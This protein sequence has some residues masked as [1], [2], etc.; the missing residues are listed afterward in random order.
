MKL[1]N[2]QKMICLFIAFVIIIQPLV[3]S[4]TVTAEEA[5]PT[6]ES[7]AQGQLEV[8]NEYGEIETI[9]IEKLTDA[10][11][12]DAEG[13]GDDGIRENPEPIDYTSSEMLLE[14]KV[15]FASSD[16]LLVSKLLT[17]SSLTPNFI[18]DPVALSL[19]SGT[20]E[21][22]LEEMRWSDFENYQ[23]L[24]TK[25]Q[26]EIGK[27]YLKGKVLADPG[28]IQKLL[29]LGSE[30]AA[31]QELANNRKNVEEEID[32][33]LEY[34]IDKKIVDML[35]YL[36]RPKD[37]PRGGAGHWKIKV[38]RLF[39]NYSS[40]DRQFSKES[41][42]VA[43]SNEESRSTSAEGPESPTLESVK[44]N[45]NISE[46]EKTAEEIGLN[47]SESLVAGEIIDKDGNT[48]SDF[49]INA[50]EAPS[51]ISS[52]YKG[53]AVD[54]SALDDIRCTKIEKKR[55]GSDKKTVQA[56]Q[57]IKFLWQTTEGY[58]KDRKSID[59]SYDK[60]MWNMGQDALLTMLSGL[61]LDMDNIETLDVRN[62]SDLASVIGQAFF[63]NALNSSG[64]DI[65]K[66][67]L[68]STLEK[69]GGIIIADALK[70]DRR[71]FLDDSLLSVDSISE[72]IGRAG[73][74]KRLG[75][76]Y[77]AL[78]GS[79]RQEM[80]I[81]VG[82]ARLLHE[83]SLPSDTLE[84]IATN[85]QEELLFRIG[86]R[87]FEDDLGLNKDS[88]YK[89][90][91]FTQ[92]SE[93]NGKYR[94][95]AMFSIH[96]SIDNL[97]GIAD[98]SS[99]RFKAGGLTAREYGK[100][101]ALTHLMNT[102]YKYANYGQGSDP[103][104]TPTAYTSNNLKLINWRD[105]MF[106][107]PKGTIDFFLGAELEE[108]DYGEIG[109]FSLSRIFENSDIGRSNFSAWLRNPSQNFIVAGQTKTVK[110]QTSNTPIETNGATNLSES[111][112]T[113]VSA[114]VT[115]PR[116]S[117]ASIMGI[118]NEEVYSVLGSNQPAQTS[119]VFKR[120]G[121]RIFV[122]ALKNSSAVKEQTNEFLRDHPDLQEN[123]NTYEFYNSRYKKIKDRLPKL[124]EKSQALKES[125]E[126]LDASF[127]GDEDKAFVLQN[128]QS[129]ES[130]IEGSKEKDDADY[131]LEL[132]RR[133]VESGNS[134]NRS[135]TVLSDAVQRNIK[136]DISNFRS[137][138]NAY[139]YEV[140]FISKNAYEILTG[141][142]Q[143][144][145]RLED[146]EIKNLESRNISLGGVSISGMELAMFLTG[147]VK[148]KELMMSI[149]SAKLADS[150][151][152]PPRALKYA[153]KL[154]RK[155]MEKKSDPKNAF[156]RAIGLSALELKLN[157]NN[158]NWGN[159]VDVEDLADTSDIRGFRDKLAVRLD[160]NKTR[161]N[162]VIAESLG[163]KGYNLEYLMRG[164][165]GAWA[166]ARA[167]AEANDKELGIPIGTTEN[168]VKGAPL[169][170]AANIAVTDD[171]YRQ[172]ATKLDISEASLRLFVSLANGQEN[173][174]INEIYFVDR[175]RYRTTSD[176]PDVCSGKTVPD[177]V[178]MYYD[179]DG[180]HYF[181]S[182]PEAN[183]FVK[184]HEHRKINYLDDIIK[185]LAGIALQEPAP[186]TI[187]DEQ[188][189]RIKTSLEEYVGGTSNF[190]LAK[191]GVD[192]EQYFGISMLGLNVKGDI[193]TDLFEKF[194]SHGKGP[195]A[196]ENMSIDLLKTTGIALLKN[197]GAS[198]LGQSL[199]MNLGST[200]LTT[201]DIY[202]ALNGNS[203]EVF[204]RIGG[205]MLDQE[206]GLERGT[207]ENILAGNSSSSRKC[208]IERAATQILGDALGIEGLE[209]SG[210]LF[211]NIGGSKIERL[212]G[213][214]EGSF[215]GKNIA[216]LLDPNRRNHVPY[217]DF[218]KGFSLPVNP[219][220]N[221]LVDDALAVMGKEYYERFKNESFY[222]KA[223]A[224]NN[225]IE[226]VGVEYFKGKDMPTWFDSSV[227]NLLFSKEI[228]YFLT[229]LNEKK[230]NTIAMGL[231]LMEYPGYADL[232][233]EDIVESLKGF[234]KR[235][236]SIDSALNIDKGYTLNL[237]LDKISPDDYRKKVSNTALGDIGFEALKQAFGIESDITLG[238]LNRFKSAVTGQLT[239]TYGNGVTGPAS[240]NLHL[241]EIYK[242]L[243][244]A[245]SLKLDEQAGFESGTIASFIQDPSKATGILA[246][247]SAKRLD[248][249]LGIDDKGIN[250]SSYVQIFVDNDPEK[251]KQTCLQT[252]DFDRC[253]N[254]ERVR[255]K[256]DS[257]IM[258]EDI[259]AGHIGNFLSDVSG[260]EVE[261]EQTSP[262]GQKVTSYQKRHGITLSKDH[263]KDVF[264]GD[265]R[266]FGV[267]AAIRG[268][269]AVLGDENGR[270]ALGQDSDGFLFNPQDIVWAFYG[271]P[272]TEEYAAQ[273]AREQ[274]YAEHN[275]SPETIDAAI[276]IVS[277]RE[278]TGANI[279]LSAAATF[280][281]NP[282]A[283]TSDSRQ[284]TIE[285]ANLTY[286][287]PETTESSPPVDPSI[288]DFT[289]PAGNVDYEGYDAA[290]NRNSI[291]RLDADN[292]A[293]RAVAEDRKL[294]RELFEYRV[295]DCM[296]RKIDKR[297]PAGFS[298]SMLKGNSFVRSV[299]L[300]NYIE[301]WLRQDSDGEWKKYLPKG[302]LSFI[303][304]YFKGPHRG[305]M[306]RLIN[307]TTGNILQMVDDYLM[308]HSPKVFGLT[309][310]PG[311]AQGL[312]AFIKTGNI[313]DAVMIGGK[314]FSLTGVY[315]NYTS[316]TIGEHIGGW[317]DDK[318]GLPPGTSYQIYSNLK[319]L[320]ATKI[321]SRGIKEGL[322]ITKTTAEISGLPV[323]TKLGANEVIGTNA[324]TGE[325]LKGD[326]LKSAKS[327]ANQKMT[328]IKASLVTI[329][330]TALF[331]KQIAAM[332]ESLGLVPGS[333]GLL[334]G[335][336][337]GWLMGAS[338]NPIGAA[339]FV[340]M[341]L[342]GVYKVEVICTADGYYPAVQPKTDST[343]WD[344]PN[345]GT[346]NAL[347][348]K[349][350]EKRYIEASQYKTNRLAI[351]LFEM[352]VR[353]GDKDLV[354]LQVMTGREESALLAKPLVLENLCK[355]KFDISEFMMGNNDLETAV[356]AGTKVGIWKN[357]QN[358]DNTHIGF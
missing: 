310:A 10:E 264:R 78:K 111:N 240:I 219:Q 139:N 283:T 56:P 266:I 345:L 109:I 115:L 161:A 351:D 317:V 249:S 182:Y 97:F 204:A 104:Q 322:V 354:P 92:M 292:A 258:V 229:L 215:R 17:V 96:S 61:N 50:E 114:D 185:G 103:T 113:T 93:A 327:N 77:G 272:L 281:E 257:R 126:R 293:A 175:N 260:V 81:N 68:G 305:D 91:S 156:Y 136:G 55:I 331:S 69:I 74:E 284:A 155:S 304:E 160:N 84:G 22:E 298:W 334:V 238:D 60:M 234:E 86:A 179:Q 206:I 120:L 255:E 119:G 252:P 108:D 112:T 262:Y 194:F 320:H 57:D 144:D 343:K 202:E 269:G 306:D 347:N 123:I 116:D 302:S 26:S 315:K 248:A 49:L 263:I 200:R 342:F 186:Y 31:I 150:L 35:A 148:A 289:D 130:T 254:K 356:C 141:Q 23:Q 222:E 1:I 159:Q 350:R 8:V 311:T 309:L 210:S 358:N 163:L 224:A 290:L 42:A 335:M 43:R 243:N 168:F 314:A 11:F 344:N 7:I 225:Y 47:N 164:D 184:A 15:V 174:A 107:L 201:D 233:S 135:V 122:Q 51:N 83:L 143:N 117:Y 253:M 316:V 2:L 212:L 37:D 268:L 165:F 45:E 346:F 296:L 274:V 154:I 149:G 94:V 193:P 171:D 53:M 39:K 12:D 167:Q 183:E 102:A 162:A 33:I 147:K 209:L 323:G 66:F 220:F 307:N 4:M 247:Q 213:F 32:H 70:L 110:N 98:G 250:F 21:D 158:S 230:G 177:N 324:K 338:F 129:M 232:K 73:V 330:I 321:F 303:Y 282:I 231:D 223:K 333:G 287:K 300:L 76:P 3:T 237:L 279:P 297:I 207:F 328:D 24:A 294:K 228:N 137:R 145:F 208:A 245:F 242:F 270:Y 18:F 79:T 88:L 152:L 355:A 218:Y 127:L 318:F 275:A 133:I 313:R 332:E 259:V 131:Y 36:V 236:E 67:D 192:A 286:K 226:A 121:E 132:S 353:T 173:P 280:H 211:N 189:A 187:S 273:R 196:T 87:I 54:I 288:N 153:A 20:P 214:P 178:F 336:A 29:G 58:A 277:T 181:N 65:W 151:N 170:E 13:I 100:R 337:V 197:F 71:P 176:T 251:I 125:V 172:M 195:D 5:T 138:L 99:K 72:G 191:I 6:T 188:K 62:F 198:Y 9:A 265:L 221:K 319:A 41:E 34:Q 267:F 52:H 25:H 16:R 44:A 75:L 278:L 325:P 261:V 339:I 341:N 329:A 217:V 95:E 227:T 256:A 244:K 291:I 19:V 203:R 340:V 82:K 59:S 326:T 105:E 352:P 101:I 85:S 38:G 90:V 30:S 63:A 134:S 205:N 349:V 124:K 14:S 271:D 241:A 180:M 169:K 146:M 140:E 28:T 301:N 118:S 285:Y 46:L 190:A 308:A 128:L 64:E 106:N 246:I 27:D 312:F 357:P 216:E 157:Q 295:A 166:S 299:T 40:E 235:L 239:T 199:G 142:E 80:M 276:T 89:S 348:A 48:V